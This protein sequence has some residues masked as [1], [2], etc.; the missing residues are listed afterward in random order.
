MELRQYFNVIKRWWW[1]LI[2]GM[3]IPMSISYHF[4]SEQPA[5]YQ[6]KVTLMVG[7]TLQQASP[8]PGLMRASTSLAQAYTVL[9][10]RQPITQAVIQR[11]NLE[12]SPEALAQQITAWVNPE[13]QLLEIM[14]TDT[15]PQAATL[16]ANA[17]AEELIRQSP[18]SVEDSQ[19][20]QAFVRE[21][22][23]NLEV[24]IKDVEGEMRELSDSIPNLTSAAEIEEAQQRLSGLQD[25]AANYRST[26]AALLQSLIDSS[27]NILTVVEPAIEP[28]GPVSSRSRL[29]LLVAG[30]A[31]LALALGAAFVIE[32]LDDTLRLESYKDRA[33]LD[34]PV[35]GLMPRLPQEY[36]HI[37]TDIPLDSS[38]A[39]ALRLL[40]AN[41][42]L[43][44]ARR[45]ISTI[46][47][48]SPGRREGMTAV[49]TSPIST[50][51]VTSPGRREGRT[52]IVASLGMVIAS[53]G[54]RV[55]IVDADLRTP[56]LHEVFGLPNDY[57]LCE[58]L[59]GHAPS[60]PKALQETSIPNLSLLAA[61]RPPLD[62]AL[63]LTSPRLI[64]LFEALMEQADIIIFD[65]PPVLLAPDTALL[66]RL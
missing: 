9:V 14:V 23:A 39:E 42:F 8:D 27:T 35:V 44:L 1:L 18:T 57:G 50:M 10:K 37:S 29:I 65:S 26:Y 6:A 19:R 25:V 54:Q 12:R 63:A 40:R 60:L 33:L 56:D 4:L 20:Q 32:F 53:G 36:G 52:T 17:L 24:K 64:E 59:L 15:N 41:I 62:L 46:L 28:T 51:L 5:L 55:I 21:Q 43:T 47:A 3:I 13:A 45:S 31:G 7:T 66:S 30:A 38:E 49:V 61:G 48:T 2:V 58:L 34:L 11:L 22:L 16:I